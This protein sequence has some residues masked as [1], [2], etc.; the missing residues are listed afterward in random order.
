MGL[1]VSYERGPY[2]GPMGRARFL[3][4]E[5]PLYGGSFAG[6]SIAGF[7]CNPFFGRACRWAMLGEIKTQRT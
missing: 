7:I 3:M 2:S 5:A 4:S 1:A 6:G